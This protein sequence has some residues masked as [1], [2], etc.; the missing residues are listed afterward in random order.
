MNI[1]HK[2]MDP[3]LFHLLP[4]WS[5]NKK[6]L[7]ILSIESFE[8]IPFH[9]PWYIQSCQEFSG[10]WHSRTWILLPVYR[11]SI[12]YSTAVVYCD[13]FVN[14]TYFHI[15]LMQCMSQCLCQIVIIVCIAVN[16]C[17][18]G[19]IA[20]TLHWSKYS[21]HLFLPLFDEA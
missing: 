11:K 2:Y 19:I 9:L 18:W 1:F 7:C 20:Q 12:N 14:L 3:W 6:G 15:F 10:P 17:I 13:I 5:S 21:A 8:W 4:R 16:T